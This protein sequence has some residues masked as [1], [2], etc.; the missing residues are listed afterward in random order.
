MGR[1]QGLYFKKEVN[2]G[3]GLEKAVQFPVYNNATS[4]LQSWTRQNGCLRF[5]IEA[6]RAKPSLRHRVAV[7]ESPPCDRL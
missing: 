4:R 7:D 2:N 6:A 1:Q 3:R 5:T